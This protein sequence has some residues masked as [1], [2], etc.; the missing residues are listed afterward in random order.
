[1]CSQALAESLV[2][3]EMSND[4]V[5][6]KGKSGQRDPQDQVGQRIQAVQ[7]VQAVVE[8]LM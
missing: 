4:V 3:D 7:E 8:R 5:R 1:M 6:K 2:N